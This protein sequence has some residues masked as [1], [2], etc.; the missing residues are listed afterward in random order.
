MD[1]DDAVDAHVVLILIGKFH[2]EDVVCTITGY[3]ESVSFHVMSNNT[4]NWLKLLNGWTLQPKDPRR[5]CL[6]VPTSSH[7]V[8]S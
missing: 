3:C 6:Q 8:S 7:L 4:H 5:H 2:S 1:G